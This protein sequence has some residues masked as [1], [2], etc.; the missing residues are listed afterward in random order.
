[1]STIQPTL[2]QELKFIKD[3]RFSPSRL[4]DQIIEKILQEVARETKLDSLV[5]NIYALEL[6][7]EKCFSGSHH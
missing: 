1:M 4:S 5:Q 3:Y 6:Q 7:E 2:F